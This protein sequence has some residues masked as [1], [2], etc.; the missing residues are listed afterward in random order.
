MH[1]VENNNCAPPNVGLFVV[2]VLCVCLFACGFLGYFCWVFYAFF[3]INYLAGFVHLSTISSVC[4]HCIRTNKRCLTQIIN[5]TERKWTT[6]AIVIFQIGLAQWVVARR[7]DVLQN[8]IGSPWRHFKQS[9]YIQDRNTS[10]RTRIPWL[11]QDAIGFLNIWDSDYRTGLISSYKTSTE[12]NW[13]V[14]IFEL[15]FIPA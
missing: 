8:T 15:W 14:A 12:C 2:A 4:L 6:W 9:S 13:T 10:G 1:A 5:K 7:S 3:R 11:H